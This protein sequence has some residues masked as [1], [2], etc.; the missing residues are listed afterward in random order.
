MSS[1][2]NP[3]PKKQTISLSQKPPQT[4]GQQDPRT[5][6][7]YVINKLLIKAMDAESREA[8]QFIIVNDTIHLIH[9][10]R[11]LLFSFENNETDLV[12]ISGLTKVNTFSER[13]KTLTEVVKSIND[14]TKAQILSE[15]AFWKEKNLWKELEI[16][17]GASVMWLPLVIDNKLILG[18]WIEKW[19]GSQF[20]MLPKEALELLNGTLMP[21][22]ASEWLKH[23]S[24]FSL[25][26]F[27]NRDKTQ[28]YVG[29]FTLFVL[30]L[31]IHIPLRVIAPCEI[32]PKDPYVISAPLEGIIAEVNVIPGQSVEKNAL[33]ASYDDRVP[34]QTLIVAEKQVDIAQKELN[35]VMALGLHDDKSQTEL[36]VANQKLQKEQASLDLAKYQASLL[37][38]L[39]PSPGVVILDNP[40]D[41]RGK[42]VKVGEKIM[43]VANPKDTK[44][45]MWIPESDNVVLRTDIPVKIYLNI[46]PEIS[47]EAN[48]VYIANESVQNEENISSFIA[49][50]EWVKPPEEAKL[51]LKGTAILY[52][53]NV[54]FLYYVFRKP[55]A[56][57]RRFTGM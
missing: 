43:V 46:T 53:D 14:P 4:E 29:G 5:S 9:Y 23:R 37:K 13:I 19:K 34:L 15:E 33:L 41:W 16:A 52:G 28:W 36:G 11:A 20:K 22:F 10:D 18:L 8:L 49:E 21:G 2:D 3:Q 50:A 1:P 27:L 45:R 57:L 35:R 40:E 39:S 6:L 47:Y 51:G 17:S 7:L 30:S 44:V 32:I 54:P 55:W 31:L 48:L 38:V 56:A 42:P 24:G 12:A 25:K 26:H